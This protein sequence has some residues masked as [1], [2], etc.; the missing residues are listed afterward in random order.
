MLVGVCAC[1]L[2]PYGR[3]VLRLGVQKKRIAVCLGSN[4]SS[5]NELPSLWTLLQL[6]RGV[7]LVQIASPTLSS[8][9]PSLRHMFP[10]E[11][12]GA[13]NCDVPFQAF[14]LSLNTVSRNTDSGVSLSWNDETARRHCALPLRLQLWHCVSLA[15]HFSH[16]C[17]SLL[18]RLHFPPVCE[19]FCW[20]LSGCRRVPV[21]RCFALYCECTASTSAFA[22]S[23]PLSVDSFPLTDRFFAASR[24]SSGSIC[25]FWKRPTSQMLTTRWSL[26]NSSVITVIAVVRKLVEGH[27]ILFGCLSAP[28]ELRTFVDH[29]HLKVVVDLPMMRWTFLQSSRVCGGRDALALPKQ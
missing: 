9:Q 5:G 21:A 11:Y 17:R 6:L 26:I 2:E 1:F 14:F 13:V 18:Q 8:K 16:E 24:V 4:S 15:G 22:L 20:R 12:S 19:E 3:T 7:D 27:G 23:P 25:S 10:V 29:V 28:V